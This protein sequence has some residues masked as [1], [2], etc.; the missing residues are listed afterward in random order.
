MFKFFFKDSSEKSFWSPQ[1]IKYTKGD[2]FH[3]TITKC[4]Y[5]AP[6]KGPASFLEYS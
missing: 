1:D 4:G 3:K 5:L 6:L 2:Q